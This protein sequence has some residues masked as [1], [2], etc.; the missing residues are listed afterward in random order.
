M[1]LSSHIATELLSFTERRASLM[2]EFLEIAESGTGRSKG[3]RDDGELRL[4]LC[5]K[6][7]FSSLLLAADPPRTTCDSSYVDERLAEYR[8]QLLASGTQLSDVQIETEKRANML[9]ELLEV[10][11]SGGGRSS[12]G[13]DEDFLR[14]NLCVR[15]ASSTNSTY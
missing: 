10:L 2:Q 14:H 5:A 4:T 7:S 13:N 8:A 9:E 1:Q 12:M 3:G 6:S 11:A 15:S